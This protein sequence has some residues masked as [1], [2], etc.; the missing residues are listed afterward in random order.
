M[1]V[2]FTGCVSHRVSHATGLGSSQNSF[3]GSARS[4]PAR[5]QQ[6]APGYSNVSLVGSQSNLNRLSDY[7]YRRDPPSCL[8]TTSSFQTPS[9]R[10][11]ITIPG[12]LQRQHLG[13]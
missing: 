9:S 3:S 7:A 12:L 6:P 4:S 8:P 10:H 5:F 1:F 13:K 11:Q 2:H